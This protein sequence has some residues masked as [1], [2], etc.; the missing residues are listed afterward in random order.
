[1]QKLKRFFAVFG[2]LFVFSGCN[3]YFENQDN[4]SDLRKEALEFLYKFN[5]DEGYFVRW[6]NLPIVIELD[7]EMRGFYGY[8]YDGYDQENVEYEDI[9][10]IIRKA[11]NFWEVYTGV[12]FKIVWGRF[13]YKEPLYDAPIGRVYV[14]FGNPLVYDDYYKDNQ[15]FSRWLWLDD[16]EIY[17]AEIV[18][19]R[20]VFCTVLLAHELGH[21]LGINGHTFNQTVTDHHPHL[22]MDPVVSEAIYMLYFEFLPGELFSWY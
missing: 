9:Y 3:I 1:M 7:P 6:A 20:D 2:I 11:A 15:A 4:Y 10:S 13:S 21:I 16:G 22:K 18:V 19:E 5:V 14:K 8:D 17:I 12:S